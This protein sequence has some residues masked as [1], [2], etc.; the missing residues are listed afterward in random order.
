MACIPFHIDIEFPD[1]SILQAPLGVSVDEWDKYGQVNSLMYYIR[2]FPGA[3]MLML[4]EPSLP[5]WRRRLS[6][7][8]QGAR[9]GTIWNLTGGRACICP[10]DIVQRTEDTTH[11]IAK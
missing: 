5:T 2:A 1:V 6:K 8:S 10:C 4:A 7:L 3:L 9:V 11:I